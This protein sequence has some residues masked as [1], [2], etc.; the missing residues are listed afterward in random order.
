L[1]TINGSSL[2]SE[3]TATMVDRTSLRF[4]LTWRKWKAGDSF[5]PLGMTGRKKISDF[6]IDQKVS[7]VDKGAVSVLESA[8]EIAWVV[9]YRIDDRFKVKTTTEHVLLMT[10]A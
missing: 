1:T 6:L 5:F 4:P 7:L 9:G 3:E 2:N 8:G 10:L